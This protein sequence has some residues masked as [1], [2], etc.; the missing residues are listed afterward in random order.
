[1]ATVYSKSDRQKLK[2]RNCRAIVEI[3][4]QSTTT[5][6]DL[7]FSRSEL[8]GGKHSKRPPII[9]FECFFFAATVTDNHEFEV[10]SE[11]TRYNWTISQS[12]EC[13]QGADHQN[14]IPSMEFPIG[15]VRGSSTLSPSICGRR[16][17]DVSVSF[18]YEWNSA[19]L[20]DSNTH[21]NHLRT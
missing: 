6:L 21:L 8:F 17:T 4:A 15:K 9:E 10:N 11:T 1:M 12:D 20:L 18:V 14:K 19:H 2:G 3:E 16:Q 5:T 13:S 7:P